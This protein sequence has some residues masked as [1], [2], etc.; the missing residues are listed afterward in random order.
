MAWGRGR[1]GCMAV[2]T[3]KGKK[4]NNTSRGGCGGR[5]RRERKAQKLRR[6]WAP[7]AAGA[8]LCVLA[9]TRPLYLS[10]PMEI[11]GRHYSFPASSRLFRAFQT[12]A[13]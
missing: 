6:A 4:K 5:V 3:G 2:N 9:A 13:D 11:T 1:C 8:L 12:A 10:P 7:A